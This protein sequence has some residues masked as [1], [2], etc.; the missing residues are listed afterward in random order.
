MHPQYAVSIAVLKNNV[1]A[2]IAQL[3]ER[4]LAKVEVAGSSPVFRSKYHSARMVKLVDTLDLKSSEQQCSCG[5]KSRSEYKKLQTMFEAFF[6]YI[7]SRINM[8][9]RL[10]KKATQCVALNL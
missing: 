9:I 1:N 7:L 6:V 3:V 4:D 10:N 5:F 2:K 8:N